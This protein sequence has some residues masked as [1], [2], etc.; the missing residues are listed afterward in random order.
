MRRSKEEIP[1]KIAGQIKIMI[2]VV[3]E[4]TFEEEVI[5]EAEEILLEVMEDTSTKETFVKEERTQQAYDMIN[6]KSDVIIAINLA[7]MLLIAGTKK[8]AE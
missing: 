5:D 6:L 8:V 1:Y 4:V 3:V 7:I 2:E